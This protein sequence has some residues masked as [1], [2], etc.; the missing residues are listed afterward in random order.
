M[1]PESC[2]ILRYLAQR[3]K[4]ADHWYPGGSLPVISAGSWLSFAASL[5]LLVISRPCL[6]WHGIGDSP[7]AHATE[8][9]HIAPVLCSRSEAEG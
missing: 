6:R 9:E 7:A 2:A 8:A 1:L 4:V 3:H 5:H